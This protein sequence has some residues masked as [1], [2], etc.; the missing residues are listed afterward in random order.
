MK[1]IRHPNLLLFLGACTKPGHLMIVTELLDKSFHDL[2]EAHFPLFLKLEMAREAAKG[3]SWLHSLSPVIIHRDL[4]PENI[5]IADGGKIV[6]VADFG[7]SL[8]KD[9]SKQEAEEMKKIRGSPA[10]MSPEALQGQVLTSKTDVYSFGMIIWELLTSRSPYEDLEVENLEELIVEICIKKTREKIPDDCVPTLRKLITGC[11]SPEPTQRPDFIQIITM[12]DDCLLEV[13]I[14]E[15]GGRKFWKSSFTDTNG[16]SVLLEV[17]WENFLLSVCRVLRISE[18]NKTFGAIKSLLGVKENNKVHIQSFGNL[19][20]WFG[21]MG[22]SGTKDNFVD[23]ISDLCQNRWFHGDISQKQAEDLLY[24]IGDQKSPGSY[25]VRLSS[26]PGLYALSKLIKKENQNVVV[27]VRISHEKPNNFSFNI[28]NKD[29]VFTS[30]QELV[31]HPLLSL[32]SVCPG[33]KYYAGQR[34]RHQVG[35]YINAVP[36]N[37]KT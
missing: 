31:T 22:I 26:Q 6:K 16:P 36:P 37:N 33:S 29:F 5:L 21:P 1:S 19:L 28:D 11:W 30:L 7:L 13:G 32:T 34:E 14:S 2:D 24:A 12:L 4:K 17:P 35:G 20:K 10:F 18:Q 3:I 9:H 25:L 27:H 15:E 23:R 8:V